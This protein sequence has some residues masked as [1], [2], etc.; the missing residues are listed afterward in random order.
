[1]LWADAA[2]P[3]DLVAAVAAELAAR[4]D[5]AAPG[6]AYQRWLARADRRAAGVYYTPPALIERVLDGALAPALAPGAPPPRVLDP[7]CGA[8]AFLVAALGRLERAALAAGA[9]PGRA[10]RARLAARLTGIDRDP[11]AA[12]LA[13]LALALA[14]VGPR[15]RVDRAALAAAAPRVRVADALAAPPPV[16]DV[17]VGNPPWGQKGFALDPAARAALRARFVTCARGPIDAFVPF[18]ELAH[19]AL[20]PGGR[21][22]Y[23]LPDVVLLKA[24][25]AVRGFVLAGAALERIVDVGPVFPGVTLDAV[26]V[27]ARVG[28]PPPDH[29]VAI[30]L[31][32]PG[33]APVRRR[34]PQAAFAALPGQVWNLHL[35]PAAHAALAALAVR[36]RLGERCEIH[37]GVHSGNARAKLFVARRPRRGDRLIV[38]GGELAR[39]R[40][41]W[42]G[43][44][45]DR[46]PAAL[47][48]AAG[49]YANLGRAAWFAAPKLVVRRT[50]D[51]V[52]A[53]FDPDGL[54]VSNNLFVVLPRPGV[55]RTDLLALAGLLNSAA[56]TRY[57][58]AVVPRVGRAFAE[59]KI[60]HL[61]GFPLPAPAA[62]ARHRGALAR[63]AARL[64]AAA[65]ADDRVTSARLARALDALADS[66]YPESRDLGTFP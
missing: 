21:W 16:A 35:E 54:V 8:G 1:V 26:V 32:R 7:A 39:F 60:H 38:G 64:A 65:A 37:E 4:P 49:D 61:A 27:V 20:A 53:A 63:L 58:R 34:T 66:L 25:A 17:V 41:R 36:P 23:V 43:A 2:L 6:A 24:H 19:R 56:L 51:R 57:F 45:L 55:G 29:A 18:V 48:R 3:P 31:A 9:R 13:R 30:E 14:I 12:A 59:L 15:G 52:I 33:A 5:P 10:L 47:D 40:L 42:A 62:Y 11:R 50:G 22:G 28:P 46:G 44:W